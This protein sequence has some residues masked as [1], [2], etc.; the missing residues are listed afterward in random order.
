MVHSNYVSPIVAQGGIGDEQRVR[1]GHLR[2]LYKHVFC[3][4]LFFMEGLALNRLLVYLV[5]QL[6]RNNETELR[7]AFVATTILWP[8]SNYLALGLQPFPFILGGHISIGP[9]ELLDEGRFSSTASRMSNLYYRC[10]VFFT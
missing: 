7:L 1:L 9:A 2:L 4:Y 10:L 6:V 3:R 5:L 8:T